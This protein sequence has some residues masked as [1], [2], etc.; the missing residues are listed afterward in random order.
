MPCECVKQAEISV[1]AKRP[2]DNVLGRACGESERRS[3]Q[4]PRHELEK[5]FGALKMII[6]RLCNIEL[7]VREMFERPPYEVLRHGI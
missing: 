5:P 1:E 3:C 4:Y 2:E 7:I 6:R